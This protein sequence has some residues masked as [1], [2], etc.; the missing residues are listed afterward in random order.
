MNAWHALT[1]DQRRSYNYGP[2]ENRYKAAMADFNANIP[3]SPSVSGESSNDS[4]PDE[5]S[6]A[7]RRAI[8]K[9]NRYS[10]DYHKKASDDDLP[11]LSAKFPFLR[12]PFKIRRMVYALI[13]S[14]HQSVIQMKPDGSGKHHNGPIDLRIALVSK[15]LF[16]AVMT[17]F[18][19]DTIIE[20]EILPNATKGLP[21]LFN[22]NV[23]SAVYWPLQT[24]K[25]V[26][27]SIS[28]FCTEESNF[29]RAELLK[30]V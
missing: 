17:T 9:W 10:R 3:L 12:L 30:L 25:S 23:T 19:E 11:G 22:S 1:Y 2:R 28:Y 29:V 5:V 7:D 6:V 21:I 13:V 15:Q 27:I 18:F 8:Q 26:N 14:R 4:D 20:L 24:I 16:T